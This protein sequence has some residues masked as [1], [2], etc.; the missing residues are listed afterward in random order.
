MG[1]STLWPTEHWTEWKA[2]LSHL[3]LGLGSAFPLPHIHQST[4][5]WR[6]ETHLEAQTPLAK[7]KVIW[8]ISHR[9][10]ISFHSLA[11]SFPGTAHSSHWKEQLTPWELFI[12]YTFRYSVFCFPNSFLRSMLYI[13]Q[14]AHFIIHTNASIQTF[15]F[16]FLI[17]VL[18]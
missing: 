17:E 18:Y 9:I 12:P 15:L 5:C 3:H 4:S 16:R 10:L 6:A 7:E 1:N 14:L 8:S 2:E 13:P 11:Y